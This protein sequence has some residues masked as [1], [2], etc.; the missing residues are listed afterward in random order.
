MFQRC[1][2]TSLITAKMSQFDVAHPR[3]RHKGLKLLRLFDAGKPLWVRRAP[4]ES[5]D[6]GPSPLS[7]R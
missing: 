7:S 4:V 5:M 6:F 2:Q 3:Q 1:L